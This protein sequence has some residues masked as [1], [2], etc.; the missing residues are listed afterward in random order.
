VLWTGTGRRPCIPYVSHFK[1]DRKKRT[2]KRMINEDE[3]EQS[4]RI[5]KPKSIIKPLDR[6]PSPSSEL[7][8]KKTVSKLK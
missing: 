1:W 8:R 4:R 2:L 6:S 5:N 7:Y 3:D